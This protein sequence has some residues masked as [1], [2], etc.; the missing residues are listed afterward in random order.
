[1]VACNTEFL[2]IVKESHVGDWK[3]FLEVLELASKSVLLLK[4]KGGKAGIQVPVLFMYGSYEWQLH[5]RLNTQYTRVDGKSA[6]AINKGEVPRE[7]GQLMAKCHSSVSHA[8][9]RDL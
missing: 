9:T 2:D 1:M 7:F 3:V 5:V 8:V 6:F 4:N